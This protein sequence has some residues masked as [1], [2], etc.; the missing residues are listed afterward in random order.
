MDEA[1]GSRTRLLSSDKLS[2]SHWLRWEEDAAA[3][4]DDTDGSRSPEL[5]TDRELVPACALL[6]PPRARTRP[7]LA[8]L[9]KDSVV[10]GAVTFRFL[11]LYIHNTVAQSKN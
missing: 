1:S 8:L 7:D 3:D 9:R 10:S 5:W 6:L 4:D 2:F 11:L